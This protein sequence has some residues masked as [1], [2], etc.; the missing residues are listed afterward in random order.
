MCIMYLNCALLN[1][2][3][4]YQFSPSSLSPSLLFSSSSLSL[5]LSLPLSISTLSRMAYRELCATATTVL[6]VSSI[7]FHIP[8][9]RNVKFSGEE[10]T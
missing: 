2:L 8:Q 9:L 10:A 7:L 1:Y 5:S 4:Y 3:P 6:H